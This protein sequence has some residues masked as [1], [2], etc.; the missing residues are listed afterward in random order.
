MD[1]K[2]IGYRAVTRF[3]FRLAVRFACVAAFAGEAL[4]AATLEEAEARQAEADAQQAAT[5]SPTSYLRGT[6]AI[7]R[8]SASEDAD[9]RQAAIEAALRNFDAAL[10]GAARARELLD[11]TLASRKVANEAQAFK[12]APGDWQRAEKK[13]NDAVRSLERDKVEAAQNRGA[14]ATE[15]YRIAEGNALQARYLGRARNAV[16]EAE[17]ARGE[18]LAPRSLAKAQRLLAEAEALLEKD[19]RTS[20]EVTELATGAIYQAKVARQIAEQA[21]RIHEKDATVEDLILDYQAYLAS[22]ARIAGTTADFSSGPANVQTAIRAELERTQ[23]LQSELEERRRQVAGLE[24]ELRELD[25]RLRNVNAERRNLM[26]LVQANLRI[27]EQF[28]QVESLFTRK[29]AKVL[30][31]GDDVILRMVGLRFASGSAQLDADGKAL[32]DRLETAIEIFPRCQVRVE[33]HTDSSGEAQANQ[34]LSQKRAQA[35]AD[36]LVAN[37]G[38][39]EFRIT[40]TGHGDKRPVTSNRTAQGRAQNRRIDVVI[41]SKPDDGL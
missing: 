22:L 4:W 25:R 19:R 5:L 39:E 6:Q 11:E 28:E 17:Q 23:T 33:G 37:V 15:L 30:R 9:E 32:L 26:R 18:K 14:Q 34:A 27:R 41:V 38:V 12:L 8:A 7:E 2:R 40:A 20:V 3:S 1:H 36:Y 21:Q 29:E 35:V 13:L 24:E 10:A 31:D 16:L